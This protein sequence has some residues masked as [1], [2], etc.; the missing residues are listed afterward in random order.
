MSILSHNHSIPRPIARLYSRFMVILKESPAATA[1]LLLCGVP[2]LLNTAFLCLLRSLVKNIVLW[3]STPWQWFVHW[4]RCNFPRDSWLGYSL[5]CL[6]WALLNLLMLVMVNVF[7]Y[8]AM[9][10]Q[11]LPHLTLLST[12]RMSY[13]LLTLLKI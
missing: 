2:F 5:N 7:Q 12:L 10:L 8:M 1:P 9:V 6:I 11:P 13:M 3:V 4:Y